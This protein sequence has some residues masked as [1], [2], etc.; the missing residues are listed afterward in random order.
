[1]YGVY[2]RKDQTPNTVLGYP[3]ALAVSSLTSL[4]LNAYIIVM[5][6]GPPLPPIWYHDVIVVVFA[7]LVLT[8][9]A[10]MYIEYDEHGDVIQV[11]LLLM[12]YAPWVQFVRLFTWYMRFV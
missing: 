3:L 12:V 8:Y 5:L 7:L 6:T 4:Y 9:H 11:M 2:L 10:W 1:M